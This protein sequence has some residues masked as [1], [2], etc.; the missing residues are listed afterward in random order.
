[1]KSLLILG[2]ST[3]L[4]GTTTSATYAANLVSNGDFETGFLG[5]TQSGNNR[6]PYID[7][8]DAYSGN[9]ANVELSNRCPTLKGSSLTTW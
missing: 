6:S 8:T 1:M 2:L 3:V 4:I 7:N 5:W 9:P